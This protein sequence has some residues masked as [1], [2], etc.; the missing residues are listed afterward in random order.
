MIEDKIDEK[1]KEFRNSFSKQTNTCSTI[2]RQIS[3]AICAINWG[4]IIKGDYPLR[5]NWLLVFSLGLCV[6]YILMDFIQS[7]Y[8]SRRYSKIYSQTAKLLQLVDYTEKIKV[9]EEA[10]FCQSEANLSGNRIFYFKFFF[11]VVSI[12]FLIVFLFDKL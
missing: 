10:T 6:I 7:Y 1:L 12:L 4:L 11:I 2:G 9:L 5:D 8:L 3:F